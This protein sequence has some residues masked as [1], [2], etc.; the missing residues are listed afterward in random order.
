MLLGILVAILLAL[1]I[2]WAFIT[3]LLHPHHGH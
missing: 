2:A 3:P 1:A